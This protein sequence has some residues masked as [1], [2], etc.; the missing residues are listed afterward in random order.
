M[1]GSGPHFSVNYRPG[2]DPPKQDL[3]V[4]RVLFDSRDL[5]DT[6]ANTFTGTFYLGYPIDS[7]SDGQS[8]IKN[9][10]SIELKAIS[11]PKV[12]NERYVILDFNNIND[13]HLG[14][15]NSVAH[16]TFAVV[17]FDSDLLPP[18]A[19]KPSKGTDFYQKTIRYRPAL[20]KLDRVEV[21]FK[22]YDGNVVTSDD[23]GGVANVQYSFML[24]I[25]SLNNRQW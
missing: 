1:S 8:T 11:F 21:A 14:A 19:Q 16:D 7:K 23:V 3:L 13:H 2:G 5:P 25:T 15:T 20:N 24:E 17:Y 6:Y 22:K 9:V 12:A 10:V 18:G 4:T